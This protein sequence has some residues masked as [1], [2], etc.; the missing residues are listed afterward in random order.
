MNIYIIECAVILLAAI[1]LR[2]YDKMGFYR[3]AMIVSITII[4]AFILYFSIEQSARD[5]VLSE[6]GPDHIKTEFGAGVYAMK[7]AIGPERVCLFMLI[8]SLSVLA[9]PARQKHD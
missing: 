8:V 3:A 5:A 9:M 2:R 4:S 7:V 6:S 1:I